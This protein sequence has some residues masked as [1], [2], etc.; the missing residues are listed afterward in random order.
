[1]PDRKF[2]AYSV[3]ANCIE[4]VNQASHDGVSLLLVL[5][6]TIAVQGA[7]SS[8]SVQAGEML[9]INQGERYRIDGDGN[10]VV[11][12]LDIA[13]HYFA[14]LYEEYFHHRFQLF[15][16]Q[17]TGFLRQYVEKLKVLTARVFAVHIC[18]DREFAS[19]EINRLL[20]EILLLLVL[21]SRGRRIIA[22]R[23]PTG[24][25]RRIEK[26]VQFLDANY[27]RHLSLKEVADREH[28]SFAHLSRL[29]KEEVGV[30]FTRYLA[31]HRF[32]HGL[33]DL[34]TTNLPVYQIAQR[35]GF[36]STRQFNVLF[37]QLHGCTP[38][39]F[40]EN[41][42]NHDAPTSGTIPAAI[43]PGSADHAAIRDADPREVLDLLGPFIRANV[44]EQHLLGAYGE[45]EAL[46]LNLSD[47]KVPQR[48][49]GLDYIVAVGDLK[50]VLKR[51]IQGQ[52]ATIQQ[53]VGLRFVEIHHLISGGAI[54]PDYQTDEAVPSCSPYTNSD[55]A[56]AF[57][58]NRQISPF[59][60]IYHCNVMQGP[61]GYAGKLSKFLRHAIHVFGLD[62]MQRWHFVYFS[63][64][65]EEMG[66]P[67]F[68]QSYLLLRRVIKNMMPG[69]KVGLFVHLCTD[70][71]FRGAPLFADG[72]AHSADFLAYAANPNEQIDFSRMDGNDFADCA[73]HVQRK[74]RHIRNALKY[75]NL[76]LPLYLL[77][78]NTL[79]GDTR[80]TNGMF[81][82]GALILKTVQDLSGQVDGI[83]IWINAEVQREAL[84]K[85]ID[86]S[87]LALF[88]VFNTR[89]PAF[90]A[91]KFRQRLRGR[92]VAHGDNHLVTESCQGYQVVLTNA[93]SFNPYTS[94]EDRLLEGFRKVLK[95]TVR[96][97][98]P[99][100]YQIRR[101][102][103][104]QEHGGLY[105]QFER[106]QSRYGK[107]EEMIEHLLRL[108]VP[109]LTVFDEQ[110]ESCWEAVCDMDV[111]AIHFYEF[112]RMAP[113]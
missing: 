110:V 85:R 107:D 58:K 62:Y 18:A 15:P 49:H 8:K 88:Y 70:D 91:L 46:I 61:E 41:R 69:S 35:H 111:N 108:A 103:F 24:Y 44:G 26:V 40:R 34:L 96:G 92:I 113:D 4:S 5:R 109:E 66:N 101:F 82:R 71:D 11:A 74:T 10:N 25:S 72:A 21:H 104:D 79:T 99:G 37:R 20:A 55:A 17:R 81:F 39:R 95:V 28:V 51:D 67:A 94:I 77:S 84:P 38:R 42:L 31:N 100:S 7:G 1:M 2:A 86:I 22:G 19:L 87:S 53:E 112:R 50:E 105:R 47:A 52:I 36:S 56:I 89:R 14:R 102:I 30:S 63:E 57:L 64:A 6:G 65:S 93:A 3:S 78:W 90:H 106:L 83:G 80:R 97:L 9:L 29:F 75:H 32:E 45:A 16:E 54:L 48:L 76:H 12:R 73:H 23:A 98:Q 60:R 43:S 68:A 27:A 59:V 33:R 13:G